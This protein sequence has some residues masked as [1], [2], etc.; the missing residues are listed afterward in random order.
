MRCWLF[1][2][3]SS[4]SVEVTTALVWAW[5]MEVVIGISR[6]TFWG[7]LGVW[8]W[9][10]SFEHRIQSMT[11]RRYDALVWAFRPWTQCLESAT[12]LT[13]AW[14][15]GMMGLVIWASGTHRLH[16]SW[17]GSFEKIVAKFTS[18]GRISEVPSRWDVVTA[19]AVDQSNG[20]WRLLIM[21]GGLKG[22][23]VDFS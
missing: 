5:C 13:W 10:L 18:S 14:C 20:D 8:I 3:P 17:S 19:R 9:Y 11:A 12:V 21:A 15:V 6:R 22:R 2:K 1:F 23:W 16:E 7:G 4:Q